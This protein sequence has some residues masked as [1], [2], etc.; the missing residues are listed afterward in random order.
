MTQRSK[1]NS[2]R[3][4][5]TP[6]GN[7]SSDRYT[8]LGL[9]SAE[10]NLGTSGN[11]NVLTTNIYGARIWTN[12]LSIANVT[13]NSI[14]AGYFYGNAAFLTGLASSY[15][16]IDVGN[17]LQQYTGNLTAGNIVANSALINGNITATYFFGNGSQLS[18]V[19]T[20]VTQ[21]ING[22]TNMTA[23]NSSNIAVTIGGI[24]N[25]AVFFG[26]NLVLTGYYYGDGSK[27]TGIVT[28]GNI[29]FANTTITSNTDITIQTLTNG[30]I[31]L[32][33]G[34]TGTVQIIGTDAVGIPSGNTLQ[35][36]TNAIVGDIRYNTELS[37][38]EYYDGSNWYTVVPGTNTIT[39][40]V[41]TPNGSANAFT[42]TEAT[43]TI[44]VIVSING[45]LQQ[46]STAYNVSGNVITFTETPLTTDI[47]EV[48]KFAG[49]S[50]AVSSLAS[51]SSNVSIPVANGGINFNTNGNLALQIETGGGLVG[52]YPSII[53]TN[54]GVAT[55][56]DVYSTSLYR[57][58]KYIIQANTGSTFESLECLV[59][60]NGTTAYRTA[61]GIIS[62][63]ASL[64]NISATVSGGNVLVQY[65][66]VNNNT[67]V[68]L[69]K[70][71]LVI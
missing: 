52:S 20:S 54:S 64:G 56:V 26:S 30:N 32:D 53:V 42:L 60:H 66:S 41:I 55:N 59:T 40:Q 19:I 58:A 13:A 70:Q 35:R 12:N 44:G 22:T 4:L 29:Q 8:W 62:S 37:L 33:A 18:G 23:Y 69:S 10:P 16:N 9:D 31:Y 34:G 57:T 47:I 45:T 14:T 49:I 48:R 21:I 61:Y 36:P 2:G 38:L 39:S 63:G 25:T 1:L 5:V 24:A 71:Y 3:V 43:S 51:G 68:R 50:S 15:G 11:G 27:L 17:F 65:T 28:T 67:N 46:P 6:P 7:V